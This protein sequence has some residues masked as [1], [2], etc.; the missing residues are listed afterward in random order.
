MRLSGFPGSRIHSNP[1]YSWFHFMF[2]LYTSLLTVNL[3][4]SNKFIQLQP[5]N[6]NELADS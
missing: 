3:S 1:A 2:A 6:G 4:S 5:S